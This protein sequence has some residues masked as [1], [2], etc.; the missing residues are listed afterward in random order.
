MSNFSDKIWFKGKIVPWAEANVHVMTHA[1]HYCSSVFEG[2]RSYETPKGPAIFRLGEHTKRFFNS[3]RMYDLDIGY[4]PDEINAV[5]PGP[6]TKLIQG[7]FFGL[8]KHTTPDRFGWLDY[9]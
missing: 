2:A 3:A 4:S 1:L 5:K 7:R 6:I 9:V 8:F